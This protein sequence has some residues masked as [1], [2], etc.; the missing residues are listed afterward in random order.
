MVFISVW[1]VS[2][3]GM[4]RNHFNKAHFTKNN[5]FPSCIPRFTGHEGRL[6]QSG[7]QP[8]VISSPFGGY[9][10]GGAWQS[11]GNVHLC[12][13]SPLL[14]GAWRSCGGGNFCS[15][16]FYSG[17]LNGGKVLV[18]TNKKWTSWGANFNSVSKEGKPAH[19]EADS[20]VKEA[21]PSEYPSGDK[22]TPREY[23]S[24]DKATPREYPSGDRA[25]PR[26]YPKGNHLQNAHSLL[27]TK[28]IKEA[29][30]KLRDKQSYKMISK[31]IKTE[32]S[33]INALLSM[34]Q[35]K[36]GNLN[37]SVK[38]IPMESLN[39]HTY[40][41]AIM[42]AKTKISQL[43]KKNKKRSF[44]DI[45]YE[46]K[47][48]YKIRKQKLLELQKKLI[49]NSRL[50]QINVKR[51]F[52]KYGY[53]GLGTYFVVFF[54]TFSCCYFFVHFKYISLSDVTYW[55]EKM[56]L[57][58]YVDDNLQKKIDSLW[59]ELLFAYIASKVTEPVRIVI[60][61]LITPYIAKVVRLKRSSRI[62]SS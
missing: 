31:K 21:K 4:I 1:R 52:Q 15:H 39:E 10:H 5:F 49:T 24:G 47:R 20:S 42:N 32:K 37:G 51:F 22:A 46:E 40:R 36:R 28:K 3:G 55:S 13:P 18:G 23:P 43:L 25:S 17:R 54:V 2:R 14:S 8:T 9:K 12:R 57:T 50:A 60:T 34:Y 45:Y 56:H 6:F 11:G 16:P 41:K 48:K 33:K 30:T 38:G 53:I 19:G 62:K 29:L 7:P 44:V 26:E 35:L 61:I 27:L 58:K 59:G